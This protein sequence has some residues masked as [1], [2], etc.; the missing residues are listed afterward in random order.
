MGSWRSHIYYLLMM[1]SYFVR[2][3]VSRFGIS[4][5]FSFAVEVFSGLRVNLDRSKAILVEDVVGIDELV[6]VLGCKFRAIVS[7]LG[8]PL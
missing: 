8:L 5:L 7:H 1:P 2:Q 6:E 3:K 4:D